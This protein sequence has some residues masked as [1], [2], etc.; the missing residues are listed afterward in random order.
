MRSFL[1]IIGGLLALGSVVAGF[2]IAGEVDGAMGLVA[3]VGGLVQSMIFFA[4][5]A[6]LSRL[7]VLDPEY[8]AVDRELLVG[9]RRSAGEEARRTASSSGVKPIV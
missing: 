6:V 7:E 8:A 1:N 4:L 2:M 9:Y 3:G 5:A